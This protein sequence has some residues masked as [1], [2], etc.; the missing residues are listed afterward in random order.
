MSDKYRDEKIVK[1]CGTKDIVELTILRQA[2]EEAGIKCMDAPHTDSAY[3]DLFVPA[4]GYAD[5]YVFESD[6]PAA[7]KVVASVRKTGER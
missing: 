6:L 4:M 1:L 7:Q 2:L 3:D 5:I